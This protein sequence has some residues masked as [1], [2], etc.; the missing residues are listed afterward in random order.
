[1]VLDPCHNIVGKLGNVE[2]TLMYR[3]FQGRLPTLPT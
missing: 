3:G 2:K 1:M